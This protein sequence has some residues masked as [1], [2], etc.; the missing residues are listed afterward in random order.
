VADSEATTE[1]RET[2]MKFRPVLD[3][4]APVDD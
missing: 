4:L 3:A 1:L 2:Q